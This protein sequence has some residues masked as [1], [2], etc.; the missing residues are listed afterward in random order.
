MVGNEPKT[1]FAMLQHISKMS[2]YLAEDAVKLREGPVSKLAENLNFVEGLSR[3]IR[4]HT[5]RLRAA[6]PKSGEPGRDWW[7]E[8]P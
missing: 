1:R 7:M 3:R 2:I 8:E 4:E 5:D 6:I